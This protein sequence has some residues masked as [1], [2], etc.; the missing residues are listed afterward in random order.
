MCPVIKA[1][2]GAAHQSVQL[3]GLFRWLHCYESPTSYTT[4]KDDATVGTERYQQRIKRD[5]YIKDRDWFPDHYPSSFFAYYWYVLLL[6]KR[7]TCSIMMYK[8]FKVI[9]G[10][11]RI[12]RAYKCRLLFGALWANQLFFLCI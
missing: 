9:I 10:W 7:A 5:G 8:I 3:R 12:R 1:Q 6:I 4:T 11:W 2:R